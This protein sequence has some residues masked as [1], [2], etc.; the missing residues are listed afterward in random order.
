MINVYK[1]FKA[2]QWSGDN[3]KEILRETGK[4]PFDWGMMPI[5]WI[6]Y[7]HSKDIWKV[8]TDTEFERDFKTLEQI[9]THFK[10][11]EKERIDKSFVSIPNILDA[12]QWIEINMNEI[13]SFIYKLTNATNCAMG[14][15]VYRKHDNINLYVGTYTYTDIARRLQ[16]E[17]NPSDWLVYDC[18]KQSFA[19]YTNIE[20][21]A[22]LKFIQ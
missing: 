1:Q 8:Y 11:L 3:G 7:S 22:I 14:I 19:K 9:N 16:F 15:E 10:E 21:E 6:V 17:L 5:D 2:I 4:I 12:F 13:N 20:F 18:K